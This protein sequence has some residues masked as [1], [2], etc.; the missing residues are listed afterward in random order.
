MQRRKIAIALAFAGSLPTPLPLTWLH[1]FYLGQYLWGVVYLI[2][3]PTGVPA[4]ACC[5]EGIWYLSQSDQGFESRFPK[6][7]FPKAE[8]LL[9]DDRQVEPPLTSSSDSSKLGNIQAQRTQQ[10]A[11]AIRELDQLRQD[12]LITEYE[13][14][15]KRRKLLGKID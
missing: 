10:V 13:F 9:A 15:Q 12:G 2:L 6:V 8:T 14:E 4:V 1:K 11:I 7:R 3:M 5:I